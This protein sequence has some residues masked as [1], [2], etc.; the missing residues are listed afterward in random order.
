MTEMRT[1]Y[2]KILQHI[3]L[4]KEQRRRQL[5]YFLFQ[6]YLFIDGGTSRKSLLMTFK[7]WM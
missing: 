7:Q 1:V 5:S 2:I 4:N 6:S 3:F